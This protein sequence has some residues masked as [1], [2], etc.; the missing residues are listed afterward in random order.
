MHDVDEDHGVG[1]LPVA[2]VLGHH[3]GEVDEQP[4][5]HAHPHNEKHLD[6][7]L[8]DTGVQLDALCTS[9]GTRAHTDTYT[10]H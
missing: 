1:D 7:E 8:A 5:H 6:V 9:V 4:G 10:S 3:A 2:V